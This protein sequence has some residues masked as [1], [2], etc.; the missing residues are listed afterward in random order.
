MWDGLM[1]NIL[2]EILAK[3]QPFDVKAKLSVSMALI[4]DIHLQLGL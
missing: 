2:G 3:G 1:K 4:V